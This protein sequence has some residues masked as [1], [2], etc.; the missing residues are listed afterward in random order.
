M[1]ECQEYRQR[2]PVNLFTSQ[3]FTI[4]LESCLPGLISFWAQARF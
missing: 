3:S 2:T 4:R 1:R